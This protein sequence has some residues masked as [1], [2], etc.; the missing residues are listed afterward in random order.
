[1]DP[2]DAPRRRRLQR[3]Q[4]RLDQAI[5][6]YNVT[7]ANPDCRLRIVWGERNAE[8]E[9]KR[10]SA[11]P[12]KRWK[13]ALLTFARR[14]SWYIGAEVFPGRCCAGSNAC[15]LLFADF[16]TG[17]A[18]PRDSRPLFNILRALDYGVSLN[19]SPESLAI[20]GG[21]RDPANPEIVLWGV[22]LGLALERLNGLVLRQA[23]TSLLQ[24][25]NAVE[26]I[27]AGKGDDGDDA[28]A[29][30]NGW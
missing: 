21:V 7:E 15:C 17:V 23:L 10:R 19:I 27:I 24:S 3:M 20:G 16:N 11:P 12:G 6:E 18:L 4:D 13:A 8:L 9:Q 14:E 2:M 28:W 22:V 5:A 29:A 26:R 25:A 30:L 1:M